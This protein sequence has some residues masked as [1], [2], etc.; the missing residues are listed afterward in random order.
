MNF[1]DATVGKKGENFVLTFGSHTVVVPSDKAKGTEIDKYVGKEVTFGIRPEDVHDEEEFLQ[2]HQDSTVMANVEVT[3]LMG[4]E[5]YLYLN[6]EGSAV[7]ARVDPTS[8]AKA[9]DTIKVAFAMNKM[10]LFD[11]E[12][13]QAILN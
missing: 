9:G 8:T 12:T 6:V 4:A 10:H 1:I 5:T 13:E 2:T 11:K 3:E 7:T